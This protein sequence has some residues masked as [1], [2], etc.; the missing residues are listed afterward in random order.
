M[1]TNI[2]DFFSPQEKEEIKAAIMN[3]ELDTSGEIRIH[4]ENSCSGDVMDRA[5]FIFKKLRM[6]KTELRNGVL[7]YLAVKNRRFAIIGDKGIH[8]RVPE[9]F[10]TDIKTEMLNHFREDQ[11]TEGLI[12]A[13]TST[14]EQLKKHFPRASDDVNELSD[15]ISFGKD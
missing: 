12:A 9:T 6:N 14:G 4:I 11:F 5:A 3:A 8:A 13:V 10:W 15:E 2:K 1:G 7:I